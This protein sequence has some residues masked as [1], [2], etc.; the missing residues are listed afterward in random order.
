MNNIR[1]GNDIEVTWSFYTDSDGSK[2]PY[3][4]NNKELSLYVSG[5]NFR[6]KKIT[7]F[8]RTDNSI[9]W[10]YYGKDQIDL[11]V[12]ALELIINEGSEG[13]VSVDKCDAFVLTRHYGE[14]NDTPRDGIGLTKLRFETYINNSG[15]STVEPEPGDTP[16]GGGSNIDPKL[17]EGFIPLSRDFSDD[18]NNDFAR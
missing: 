7:Y 15:S 12:H 8:T 14:S 13:M 3:D 10:N 17:L 1:I 5:E 6:R 11:G 16:G 18:F 2:S 9:I 4:F